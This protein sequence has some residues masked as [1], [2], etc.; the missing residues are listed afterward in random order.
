M[1][2]L[3]LGNLASPLKKRFLASI[4]IGDLLQCLGIE[5]LVLLV[6]FPQVEG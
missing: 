3:L 5:L 4:S 2:F 1:G 6:L